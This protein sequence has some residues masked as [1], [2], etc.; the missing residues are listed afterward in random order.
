MAEA[1]AQDQST[2]ISTFVAH[3]PKAEL[4]VHLESDTVSA[5][6]TNTL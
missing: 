6:M 3:L 2:D 5:T 4:H 1:N